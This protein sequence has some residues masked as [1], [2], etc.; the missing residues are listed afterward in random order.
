MHV[1]DSHFSLFFS[2]LDASIGLGGTDRTR[3][4][5]EHNPFASDLLQ[6]CL[7]HLREDIANAFCIARTVLYEERTIGTEW[8]YDSFHLFIGKP[9][10]EERIDR[11]HHISGIGRT[12]SQTGTKGYEFAKTNSYRSYLR[13]ALPHCEIRTDDE[14][15]L[16]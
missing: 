9:Q 5:H 12:A 6:D 16:R 7:R 2:P 1:S 13:I 14:V 4:L 3:R 8:R 11:L 10:R 15:I